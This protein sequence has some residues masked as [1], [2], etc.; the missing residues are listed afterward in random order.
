MKKPNPK[1]LLQ[2]NYI[3]SPNAEYLSMLHEAAGSAFLQWLRYD[4]VTL[5]LSQF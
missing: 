1:R 5:A 4:I 2:H 3:P